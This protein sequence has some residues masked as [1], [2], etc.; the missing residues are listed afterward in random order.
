MDN[1]TENV[2]LFAIFINDILKIYED[3]KEDYPELFELVKDYDLSDPFNK[4]PMS[5]YN[6]LCQWIEENLGKFNL[7]RIGRTIGETVHNNLVVNKI[8]SDNARPLEVMQALATVAKEMIQDPKNR[9]WNI[10]SHNDEKIIMQRTQTFN[11]KLQLGLLDGLVRKSGVFSVN[12]DYAKSVEKG[13]EF[14]EYLIS[15]A[16]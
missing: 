10:I 11:S 14:D 5:L 15:W 4:V 7:I 3:K 13:D 1:S 16:A 6:E 8:I 2:T 12:V 9:G